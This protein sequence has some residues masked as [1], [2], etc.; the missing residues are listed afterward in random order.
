MIRFPRPH[1]TRYD[2][3]D[4][5]G[6]IAAGHLLVIKVTVAGPNSDDD[7]H[8]AFDAEGFPMTFSVVLKTSG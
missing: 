1:L 6:T 3:G 5:A 2:F 7:M 8:F 4:L